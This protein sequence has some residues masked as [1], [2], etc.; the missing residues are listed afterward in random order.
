MVVNK[1]QHEAVNNLK[2][3][4]KYHRFLHDEIRKFEGKQVENVA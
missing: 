2:N 1:V 4:N 3:N